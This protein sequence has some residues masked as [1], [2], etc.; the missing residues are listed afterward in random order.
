MSDES[1]SGRRESRS[2]RNAHR[3]CS[4]SRGCER[5][6]H[7]RAEMCGLPTVVRNRDLPR[8]RAHQ[9]ASCVAIRKWS[10]DDDW[11]WSRFTLQTQWLNITLPVDRSDHTLLSQ[12]AAPALGRAATLRWGRRCRAAGA[13]LVRC[14]ALL[15]A[16]TS[17]PLFP[18]ELVHPRREMGVPPRLHQQAGTGLNA[19]SFLHRNCAQ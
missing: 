19:I 13:T 16:E 12:C 18:V 1:S 7:P 6:G 10:H 8:V 3:C 4:Q 15:H 5:P 9:E 17:R 14:L 2:V 11:L